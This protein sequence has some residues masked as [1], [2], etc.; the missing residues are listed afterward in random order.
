MINRKG[1]Y[2]M[3]KW[4]TTILTV[5]L[6][7][8]SIIPS[9]G[10]AEET[11]EELSM[12]KKRELLTE[13]ALEEGIPPEILKA[14]ADQESQMMQ[15]KN[16][17]P[18]ISDDNGIGIMQVTNTHPSVDI[19][20]KRLKTDTAY[21]IKIGAKVLSQKWELMGEKIPSIN[22]SNRMM[23]EH[24]YFPLMAYNGASET[25]DPQRQ[26]ETY[27]EKVYQ[28]ISDDSLVSVFPMPRFPKDFFG[29]DDGKLKFDELTSQTWENGNTISTQMFQQGDEVYVMNS[30]DADIYDYGS[31]RETRD[32]TPTKLAFHTELE[33]VDGPYFE[34]KINDNHHMD[35]K[36]K[37]PN[38][39]SGYI[40]SSNL[41]SM[42][43]KQTNFT[44]WTDNSSTVEPSKTWNI[45]FNTKLNTGSINEKNI[46][47]VN[48]NG[49]GVRSEVTLSEDGKSL[50]MNPN[51]DL[52]SSMN[53]TLYIEGIVSS[54]GGKM[55]TP[56]S[57]SFT[58]SN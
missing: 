24:W 35:Y 9:V 12:D 56:I 45:N 11:Y 28:I 50:T 52:E 14:V 46:Y 26:E 22:D 13:I 1:G 55:D 44:D 30:H 27:Q 16:G 4:I 42:D 57:K 34:D 29:Y 6:V 33:I 20:K 51:A 19:D 23:L 31:L 43:M 40:S 36:V 53:Y 48:E 54:T 58:V 15:F 38:G 41:R 2:Y 37:G 3:G 21:N 8:F 39:I 10:A 18:F 7:T 49:V 17:K 25:N 32:S 47:I 5:M